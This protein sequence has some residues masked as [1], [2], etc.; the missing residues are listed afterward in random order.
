MRFDPRDSFRAETVVADA[1]RL[2]DA[3]VFRDGDRDAAMVVGRDGVLG[4]LRADGG[5]YAVREIAR[6]NQ[7]SAASPADPG[8]RAAHRCSSRGA[9]TAPC[10]V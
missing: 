7:G 4:L 2:R 3:A 5:R 8:P 1:I 9:T 10:C 6:R